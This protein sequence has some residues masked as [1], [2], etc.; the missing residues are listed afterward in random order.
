VTSLPLQTIASRYGHANRAGSP[1]DVGVLTASVC[2]APRRESGNG[3]AVIDPATK[4]KQYL[5]DAFGNLVTVL[6]PDPAT[7]PGPPS[8]P[9]AYPVTSAT[10][11]TLLTSYTYDQ[12]G[13]L[14]QVSMPR[15]TQTRIFVYD[16][17]TQRLTSATNQESGTVS[18]T[19]N[20]DGTLASKLDANG[21]TQTYTY[22]SYGRLTGIPDCHQTFTWDT[23]LVN[24]FFRTSAPCIMAEA[25]FGSNTGL[26]QLSFQYNCTYT[27]AGGQWSELAVTKTSGYVSIQGDT[28]GTVIDGKLV[29]GT[30]TPCNK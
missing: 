14:T 29:P 4:W 12:L 28:G 26:N 21:N 10:T 30:Y 22:D 19:Y 24:D 20:A 9:P 23:C 7:N 11:H 15:S 5:N 17:T 3:T 25:A 8:S 27:P 18:Y 1:Q 13:H 2:P 6:E 16:P